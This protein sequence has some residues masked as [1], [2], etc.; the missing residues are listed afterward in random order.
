MSNDKKYTRKPAENKENEHKNHPMTKE[1]V[2]TSK[3]EKIDEDFPGF[4]HQPASEQTIKH[5][6]TNGH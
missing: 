3:D 2:A 6:K 5:K 4:P 1:D